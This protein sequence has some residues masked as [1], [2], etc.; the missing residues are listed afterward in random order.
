MFLEIS[1]NL[2]ESTC[3]R[4]SFFN[5]VAGRN[6]IKKETLAQ[7]FSSEFWKIS[8]NNFSYRTDPVVA[9]V[10]REDK[11]STILKNKWSGSKTVCGFSVILI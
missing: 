4:V 1:P 10:F 2:Q 5:E 9:S 7:V 3:A 11:V 8:K 6:V